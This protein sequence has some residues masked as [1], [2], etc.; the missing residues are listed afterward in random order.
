MKANKSLILMTGLTMLSLL[1]L[2]ISTL[3]SSVQAQNQNQTSSQLSQVQNQL[4]DLTQKF[5]ELVVK[6]GVN[7]TLP[8]S[9]NLIDHLRNLTQSSGFKTLSQLLPQLSDIGINE[10]NIKNLQKGSNDIPG[11]VQKFNT[12][13]NIIP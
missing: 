4:S 2:S 8:Q 12:L 5:R 1:A 10:T 7:I 9:G 11:L 3:S 6:S 13:I